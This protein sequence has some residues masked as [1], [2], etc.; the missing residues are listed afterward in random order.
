MYIYAVRV[1]SDYS[2]NDWYYGNMFLKEEDAMKEA[3]RLL[4]DLLHSDYS[5]D[6]KTIYVY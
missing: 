2:S 3:S 6:V 4:E 5:V 1:K